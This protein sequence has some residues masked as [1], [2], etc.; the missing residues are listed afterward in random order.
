[1]SF[2]ALIEKV[3]QAEGA[4]EARERQGAADWR[5]FK[6]TWHAA[7]TPGRIMVAGL[8]SGFATGRVQPAKH[9]SAASTLRLMSAVSGLFAINRADD[10]AKQA[11]E[12][13]EAA[14]DAADCPPPP[15][16][17]PRSPPHQSARGAPGHVA[18][19]DSTAQDS[20]AHDSTAHA[21][22]PAPA[23]VAQSASGDA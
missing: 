16:P 13:A 1:M 22:T 19:H 2:E 10:A 9:V 17:H 5:Q 14:Q 6:A 3:K 23:R 4:L 7:W 15:P 20:T 8:V 21:S 18:S 12:A 11:S